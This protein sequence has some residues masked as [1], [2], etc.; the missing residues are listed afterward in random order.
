MTVDLQASVIWPSGSPI[1]ASSYFVS[2]RDGVPV[3]ELNTVTWIL[4]PLSTVTG[5]HSFPPQLQRLHL[6][7]STQILTSGVPVSL[8]ISKRVTSGRLRY[9]LGDHEYFNMSFGLVNGPFFTRHLLM[10]FFEI[11]HTSSLLYTSTTFP[12]SEAHMKSAFTA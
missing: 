6:P 2:N 12:T 10:M 4:Q 3:H 11:Y 7:T 8:L 1:A 5:Y 9:T